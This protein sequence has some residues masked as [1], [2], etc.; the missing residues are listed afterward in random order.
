[1]KFLIIFVLFCSTGLCLAAPQQQQGDDDG[2]E[3]PPPV[4]PEPRQ[5]QGDDGE[6]LPPPV[7][8]E[9]RQQQG[10]DGE[11]LPP[12]VVPEPRQTSNCNYVLDFSS[13]GQQALLQSPNWPNNY[14][15]YSNCKY[16]I[17]SPTGIYEL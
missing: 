4:K 13:V 12:P 1:M 5:Q 11:E 15:P 10:D 14:S 9:P 3:L 17:T 7:K 6:E 16:S 8:P 2:E